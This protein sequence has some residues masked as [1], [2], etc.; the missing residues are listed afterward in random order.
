[1]FYIDN[2]SMNPKSFM[3]NAQRLRLCFAIAQPGG[4]SCPSRDP[5]V[6]IRFAMGWNFPYGN[7]AF[8]GGK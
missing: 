2:P 5:G 4:C 7:G 3:F 1:M 6:A 8:H